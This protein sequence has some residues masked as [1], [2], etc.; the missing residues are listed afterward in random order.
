MGAS[1]SFA[2]DKTQNKVTE[3]FTNDTGKTFSEM[4]MKFPG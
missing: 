4:L 3:K 1:Q 2:K